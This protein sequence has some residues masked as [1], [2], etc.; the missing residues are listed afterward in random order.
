MILLLIL[1]W[2]RVG[3]LQIVKHDFFKTKSTQ[4]LRRLIKV[5]PQRGKIFDRDH[6]LLASVIPSYATYVRPQTI[7][8]KPGFAKKIAPIIIHNK[9]YFFTLVN[10]YLI[11]SQ[12]VFLFYSLRYLSEDVI[13]IPLKGNLSDQ[14]SMVHFHYF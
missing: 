7:G 5:Y 14:L 6:K 12:L 8:D 1:L 9:R 13:C 4:Q 10:Y 2:I 3:Y 11:I